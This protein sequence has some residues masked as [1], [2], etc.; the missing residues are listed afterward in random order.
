MIA[1]QN[2]TE[3]GR[4]GDP[5]IGGSNTPIVVSMGAIIETVI[6]RK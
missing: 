3:A 5:D 2:V 1:G 6:Q 4:N